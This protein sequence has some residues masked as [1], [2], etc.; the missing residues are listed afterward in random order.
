MNRPSALV[1]LCGSPLVAAAL[2]LFC[3]AVVASWT[4]GRASGLLAFLAVLCGLGTLKAA[5][6]R[7]KYEAWAKEWRA[8]G[9]ESPQAV[10]R[11]RAWLA[12]A[13]AALLIVGIPYCASPRDT[14]LRLLWP[15]AVCYFGVAVVLRVVHLLRRP[16]AVKAKA[17]SREKAPGAPAPV[18]WLVGHAMSSPSRAEAAGNLPGY[19][20]GLLNERTRP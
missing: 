12:P 13:V 8:M 5:G 3:A 19:C 18:A 2:L 1:R 4:G 6:R 14:A 7:R 11:R 9:G 15:A 20:A 10:K 17:A 16:R